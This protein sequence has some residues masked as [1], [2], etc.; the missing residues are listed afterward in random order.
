MI[1]DESKNCQNVYNDALKFFKTNK[2]YLINED[3]INILEKDNPIGY[4][5][6]VNL[7]NANNIKNDNNGIEMIRLLTNAVYKIDFYVETL[8]NL[9]EEDEDEKQADYE[10]IRTEAQRILTCLRASRL[11]IGGKRKRKRTSKKKNTKKNNTK[12]KRTNKSRRYKRR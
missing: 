3:K 9:L 8:E 7:E 10:D 5:Y 6:L 11:N 2:E 12:R 4:N 1:Y